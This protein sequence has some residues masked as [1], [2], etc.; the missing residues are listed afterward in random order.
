M[1]GAS[2]EHVRA[3]NKCKLILK[4]EK[5][6]RFLFGKR[7]SRSC[8]RLTACAIGPADARMAGRRCHTF[9]LDRLDAR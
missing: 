4:S 2:L 1:R 9:E 7:H 6:C 3:R 5:H 8:V